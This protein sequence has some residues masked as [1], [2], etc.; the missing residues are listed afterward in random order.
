MQHSA[1]DAKQRS[2]E[3]VAER[4]RQK[5]PEATRPLLTGLVAQYFRRVPADDLRHRSP[6]NLYGMAAAH[7]NLGRQRRPGLVRTQVLNPTPDRHGW[8]SSHTILQVVMQDQPFLVDSIA[9]ALN[10]RGLTIHLTIHPILRVE[11]DANGEIRGFL[12]NDSTASAD[13]EAWMHFEVD[14]VADEEERRNLQQ[15]I[16]TVIDQCR[17]V[18]TDWQPMRDRMQSVL[19]GLERTEDSDEEEIRAFLAWL[20]DQHFTYLGY[21]YYALEKRGRSFQLT[22][23]PESA[24]GLLRGTAETA[25]SS[26]SKLP[27][28]L[29]DLALEP[30]RLIVTKSIHRSPVHRPGYMDHVGI[31]ALDDNGKVIGEH[32][33]FGLYTSAAYSRNPRE[34][35]LLRRKI[36]AVQRLADLPRNSHSGKALNNLLETYPRDELFQSDTDS[37]YRISMGIL[38]LQERQRVRLFVRNDTYRR[39]VSCLVYAPRDRYDS[40]VRRRMQQILEQ[41]FGATRSEFSV[42]LSEAVLARIHFLLHVDNHQIPDVNLET[43]EQRLAG[44]ARDWTDDLQEALLDYYGEAD[45]NRLFARYGQAFSAAYREDTSPRTGAQD[46]ARLECLA[47]DHD[48]DIMLYRPLEADDHLIRLR[49]Y[50]FGDAIPLSDVL[51][52]LENMGLRVVDERPYAIHLEGQSQWIHDFGLL[53]SDETDPDLDQIRELFESGLDAIWH[54]KVENDGFNRLLLAARLAWP[55]IIILRAYARYLRQAGTA[56]SQAYIEDTLVANSRIARLLVRLFHYRLD[57]DRLDDKRAAR[58]AEQIELALADVPSLDQDRILRRLLAAIEATLRTSFYQ[59][60]NL[61]EALSLKLAPATIPDMP[62][63]HPAFE[64]YVYSPRVEGVH[65]RGGKVARGGLRWSER[66]E[67]FRTEVLGLMKAQMVKNAV[68]VPL[69]AKGGFVARQLPEEREERQREV[70][71][72]YRL[73]IRGLLNITDNYPG[74]S[75]TPPPRV[76]RHDGDDPYLVVAADKGTATFSDKA[77]E[78]AAEYG[79][80]LGDAFASG[81]SNGYD[82]KK[83]GITARGAWVA[84]QR[85]FR[86]MDH[87]IQQQPFSVVGIGDMSGDVFGNGMLLSP[88]IRLIA[89]FDHRHIFL[90][91]DPDPAIGFVERQRLFALPRSSWDDYDR[92]CLSTGGDIH[93]RSAKSVAPSAEACA[94]L[95]IAPGARTPAQLIQAILQAPVDLLWNGGIGTYIKSSG[96]SHAEVGDRSNDPVRVDA[97]ALRCRVLGEGGNLGVTQRARIEFA[98]GGGRINTDAID[99]VGGVDCSD[100]EVNIK[101]LLNGLVDNGELTERQRN[102]LLA[103]MGDEVAA[104]VLTDCDR[105][106]EALSIMQAAAPELLAEQARLIRQLEAD[107]RLNRELEALPTDRQIDER[108][109]GGE[110]L[111]RPE[112]AVLLAHGKLAGYE[113]LIESSLPEDPDLQNTLDGY[114]PTQLRQGFAAHLPSHRLRREIIATQVCNELFNRLGASVLFR[115]H[116]QSGCSADAVAKAYFISRRVFDLDRLWAAIDALN[117][118]VAGHDQISLQQD[119]LAVTEAAMLWLV[120]HFNGDQTIAEAGQRL[121]QPMVTLDQSLD[122]LLPEEDRAFLEARIRQHTEQGVPED[123]A[124]RIVRLEPLSSVMDITLMAENTRAPMAMVAEVY[125]RLAAALDL[126]WLG[127][128][129]AELPGDDPWQERFRSGL[130]DQLSGARRLLATA[131]LQNSGDSEAAVLLGRWREQQSDRLLRFQQ[132]MQ[133]LRA[134]GTAG[135]AMLSV[136]LQDLQDLAARSARGP[137]THD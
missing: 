124:R 17:V 49:L 129:I 116:E 109:A 77:N 25:S 33:F 61:E 41:G 113:A 51:P 128:T 16:K 100:H 123:L 99:N 126:R 48:L 67:D 131:L 28:D 66:K 40:V 108:M 84:V 98:Q 57:P 74:G 10:R 65:L 118:R 18:V 133:D 130:K 114:F 37:L 132:T 52:L 12:G 27:R 105:Q 56:F 88:Q 135:A 60:N 46:V 120:R 92:S 64:I 20:I 125:F 3:Q 35:P 81:G 80:W 62:E 95:G 15:D 97:A 96:E 79:F 38:H 21:R 107:G 137:D 85:H 117:H 43:L 82:H 55:E 115:L 121:Q 45:G 8:E 4:I 87:D 31:K 70:E 26:F 34:I 30:N 59:D 19:D 127:R 32:R 58:V 1:E 69:G 94:A 134:T 36:E 5:W 83:M 110:G 73:F 111:T 102:R 71:A 75:I 112:A 29:R 9:M 76:V 6:D 72:C 23:D 68:I 104:L 54:G 11:R 44:A 122:R 119:V 53:H 78:I 91:P 24:L 13:T 86:E 14:R 63:P 2:L 101:I 103:D 90:D 50:R 39:F 93:P 89:A 106:T 7:W 136:T 22:G 42:N 47:P